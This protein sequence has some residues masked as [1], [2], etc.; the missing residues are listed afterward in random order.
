MTQQPHNTANL[1]TSARRINYQGG[2]QRSQQ[3][4]AELG[5]DPIEQLVQKYLQLEAEVAYQ[6]AIREG[7][8][9]PLN[10]AG[11]PRAYNPEVHMALYDKMIAVS[12]K[13]LRYK[14]GRVPETTVIENKEKP[15]L[16]I[17][18][19]KEG[20]KY[21]INDDTSLQIEDQSDEFHEY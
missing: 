6:E 17:N 19:T 9:V 14:Y 18:L 1:T 5:F 13:L 11:K 16:V 20:E 15:P 3:K 12:D 8:I 7:T 10:A 4:L 21:I 2:S